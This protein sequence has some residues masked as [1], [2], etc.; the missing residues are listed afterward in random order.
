MYLPSPK[1]CLH[2]ALRFTTLEPGV[3]KMYVCFLLSF[4]GGSGK[5]HEFALKAQQGGIVFCF[6]VA[7]CVQDE[8][9]YYL[10]GYHGH[11]LV[12]QYRGFCAVADGVADGG[13]L[14]PRKVPNCCNFSGS[15]RL[16]VV[17]DSLHQHYHCYHCYH[18]WYRSGHHHYEPPPPPPL[19]ATRFNF[20]MSGA[21]WRLKHSSQQVFA[22]AL[23]GHLRC[24]V[25]DPYLARRRHNH[26][27]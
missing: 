7:I 8:E 26:S 20:V 14:A 2:E 5:A 16:T 25:C 10:F 15:K 12:H 21:S 6:R 13:G 3:V 23:Q 24:L 4:S 9:A 17:Q 22:A 11:I 1:F 18:D 19:P 27:L